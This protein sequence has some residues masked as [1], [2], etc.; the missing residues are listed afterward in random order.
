MSLVDQLLGRR[1]AV[2]EN[3]TA[4]VVP[5]PAGKQQQPT[6]KAPPKDKEEDKLKERARRSSVVAHIM[7]MTESDDEA[8]IPDSATPLDPFEVHHIPGMVAKPPGSV[9]HEEPSEPSPSNIHGEALIPPTSALVAPDVTP[10]VMSPLDPSQVPAAPRPMERPVAPAPVAPGATGEPR[11]A[12]MSNSPNAG[13][14]DTILGRQNKQPQ[15]DAAAQAMAEQMMNEAV[16]GTVEERVASKLIPAQ[17]GGEGMPVHKEGDG[18]SVYNA[19]RRF[20]G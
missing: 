9:Q 13:V 16:N 3:T 6:R 1:I 10:N 2:R 18:R 20:N 11:P 17:E 8:I 12:P 7:G 4:D 14:L 19:F 5:V 15:P